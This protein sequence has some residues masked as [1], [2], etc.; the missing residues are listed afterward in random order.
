MQSMVGVTGFLVLFFSGYRAADCS[1][2]TTSVPCEPMTH[3]PYGSNSLV[4]I[5]E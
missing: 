4:L 5:D 1:F 2:S 3:S